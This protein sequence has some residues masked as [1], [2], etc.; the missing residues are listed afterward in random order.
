MNFPAFIFHEL[1]IRLDHINPD[2]GRYISHTK[3]DEVFILLTDNGSLI[4]P[5]HFLQMQFENPSTINDTDLLIL[6]HNFR[7]LI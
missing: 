6:A 5:E 2:I 7:A 4:I 1:I 3:D